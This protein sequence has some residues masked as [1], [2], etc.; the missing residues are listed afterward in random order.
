MN[1][2]KIKNELLG[3]GTSLLCAGLVIVLTGA[4]IFFIASRGLSV[5]FVDHVSFSKVFF[6]SQW[7]PDR[8]AA[9]GGPSFG[10][11]PFLVGSVT[12]S[13]FAVILSAP[14]S[15]VAAFFM[16]EIAPGLGRR[17]LQPSVE[18]LAGIPSVVYG[19]IGLSVLV[20]LIRQ[21]FGGLGFSVLAGGMVLAVMILPT[22][23]SVATDRISALPN[24]YREA[25][26]ALGSTRWQ[27]IRH[28][29]FPAALPGIMTGLILGLARA[30]GEA[31]A[32][33]MVLGNVRQ[34]PRSLLQPATTLTSGIT[35]DMGYTAMGSA[36]NNVLWTM[37]LVL[38]V[39]SLGFII[40]IRL[41]GRGG[42]KP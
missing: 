38:L 37:A 2:K 33:Q 4:I 3:K 23:V 34:I 27:L 42:A 24:A 22:I 39:M 21:L 10:I 25:S 9:S 30:F 16:V 15:I 12:V 40:V 36:W 7:F 35:M 13:L 1:L 41:V 32:V 18:L 19:W 29:L 8:D 5:F 31:L 14:L 17:F 11:L 6:N 28:V 20:P 26:Y